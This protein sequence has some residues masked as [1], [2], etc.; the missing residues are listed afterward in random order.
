M[1]TEFI[2][3]DTFRLAAF[4]KLGNKL[5]RITSKSELIGFTNLTESGAPPNK[6]ASAL[7]KN[8]YVTASTMP[9]LAK[10]RR[11]WECRF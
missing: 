10:T 7:D 1:A 11:A 2:P 9:R 3:R 5:G 6:S 4:S 8:E